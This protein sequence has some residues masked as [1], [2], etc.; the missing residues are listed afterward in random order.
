M[1]PSLFSSVGNGVAS[2]L[3]KTRSS[4]STSS[5]ISGVSASFFY[6]VVN[7]NV[8]NFSECLF[9]FIYFNNSISYDLD[10]SLSKS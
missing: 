1:S 4:D 6:G 8:F 5:F 3:L 7:P 2:Y 10:I 9:K